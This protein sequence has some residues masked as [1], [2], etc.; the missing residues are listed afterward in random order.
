MLLLDGKVASAAIREQ[1]SEKVK[2]IT[3]TGARAPHLAAIL[4]GNNPASETYVASKVKNCGEVGFGSSLIRLDTSVSEQDLLAEITKLNE[5][6]NIDGILVQLPLPKH[7]NEHK[8]INAIAVNKDVDGF[9]PYNIGNMVIGTPTFIP[10]TP[11]GVMLMLE[12]FGIDTSGKHCVVL[13]RSNIVGTPASIL[14]SR[15]SKHANCTVTLCHS[16]TQNLKEIMLQA[17]IVVAAIGI[18]HFVTA[19]MIKQDAVVV[20]VGINSI[21]APERKSGKRLVGDV[22]FDNISK[23]ASAIT[24]VPGGV[25]LMTIAA[26]LM[27][28]L[29]AYNINK[30]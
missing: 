26:L 21:D 25:G 8:I 5:D 3:D 23:I 6:Q 22:D 7:I 30:G 28:T 24:P 17:D 2:A 14:L 10:A 1:L 29:T 11:Y 13:G 12:H 20:D 4:V 15:N 19:D 27:N 18:P 9:H 16:K